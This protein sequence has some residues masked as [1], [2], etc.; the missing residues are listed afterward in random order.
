[1]AEEFGGR[2][3]L[4]DALEKAAGRM[5]VAEKRQGRPRKVGIDRAKAERMAADLG[6]YDSR[7]V[8]G[9]LTGG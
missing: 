5:A 6:D 3:A 4:E 9:R 1:M 7:I 8:G 2:Q